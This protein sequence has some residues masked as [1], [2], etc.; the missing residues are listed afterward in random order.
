MNSDTYYFSDFTRKHYKEIL[1]A[2]KENY[3]F[4]GYSE[5]LQTEKQSV[6]WRHD[7]DMSMTDA[8]EIARIENQL[9]IRSTFFILLH[10]EFYNLLENSVKKEVEEIIALGHTIGLH[11]DYSYYD[12]KGVEALEAKIRM[13]AQILEHIFKIRIKSFA[14]HNPT[15][16]AL[17]FD[18]YSYAGLINTYAK[19][20]KTKF[21]YCS[22]SN[23]Y[24]RH[25]RMYD[26]VKIDRPYFLQA[27]THPVWWTEK[28][29]SPREKILNCIN[30]KAAIVL[31]DYSALLEAAGR[32]I[33][34]W[35]NKGEK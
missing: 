33:I 3:T 1:M 15:P 20:F 35:E 34:D 14:F 10:S 29:L 6:L 5:A 32:Y 26:V 21:S 18:A 27:L 22:D 7:V 24:W 16:D 25:K 8:L 11:F 23:G 19:E 4:I 17:L 28:I 12:E 30:T 13:E 31:N 9:G 2:A